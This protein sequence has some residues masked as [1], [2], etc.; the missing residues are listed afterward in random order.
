MKI[1]KLAI[2]NIASIE[3]AELDFEHGA[4]GE[5]PLFLICGETGA[6][7]T[8][9]LDC[10]TLALYGKT[11]RYDGVQ[12]RNA[13]EIGGYAYNDARQLV[14]HGAA[15]ARAALSLTGNDGKPYEAEWS[16]EAVSKGPNKGAFKGATWI[17]KDCSPGG[18]SRTKVKEC[19]AAALRATGLG[20][21]QFCRT[22]MLAQGQFTKFLLGTE[23]EKAEILEKLTDTSRYS[24]LGKAIALKYAE[25]SEGVKA[26]DAEIARIPG[27]GD[28]RGEVENRIR[29]LT[30]Q[31]EELAQKSLSANA[32]LLW[33]TRRRE[34][35]SNRDSV[36]GKLVEAFAALNAL[37]SKFDRDIAAV[38]AKLGE[39]RTFL[40]ENAGKATMFESAGVIL[41]NLADIRKA[42]RDGKK[43]ETALIRFE[44]EL[45]GLNGRVEAA[46]ATLENTRRAFADAETV[47]AAEEEKLAALDRD[48]VQKA[49]SETEKLRGNL[50]GLQGRINGISKLEGLLAEKERELVRQ[51]AKRTE[52]EHRLPGL[53]SEME[54][55]QRTVVQVRANR[56]AKKKLVEDGIE[57]LVSDLKIGDTCPIC[58]N[59]IETLRAKGHF[60]ALFRALEA[61]CVKAEERCTRIERSYGET[62]AAFDALR[63]AIASSETAMLRAKEKIARETS[64][65]S[66]SARLYGIADGSLERVDAAVGECES[67]ISA[68]DVK[69]SGIAR[70]EKKIALLR[71]RLKGLGKKRDADVDC[72]AQAEKCV[73]RCENQIK[74][75]QAAIQTERERAE[76]K[77]SDVERRVTV[78]GWL[79]GWEEDAETVESAFKD[80]AD[81]YA[82]RKA[83]LPETEEK[84]AALEKERNQI[85]ECI[86][87]AVSAD[88]TLAAVPGGGR[89]ARSTAEMEGLLGRFAEADAALER[90]LAERPEGLLETDTAENL[91]VLCDGFRSEGRE[92]NEELG[93]CRQQI[94]DDDACTLERQKKREESGRLQTELREWFPI[95]EQF[96]D[97]EGKKIRREIQSYVLENVLVKAN[98]YLEQLSDRYELS[99]EGLTLSVRDAF[100]GGVARP[101][102]T[103]SGGEQFLVSLALALGL[104]G[105][106]ETGLGVDMLLIDEGF[107][108]LSG[109][110]L[111]SAIE[112]L[113]RLNVLTGSRKVG[114]ISHV[115]RL[116][117]RIRTH[118]EV[119][120]NGHDP[121]RVQV[122]SV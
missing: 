59:R 54:C 8:T 26:L 99:C 56:D 42:R 113:E 110:H 35:A 25:L 105:T 23:D 71:E 4:L 52:L 103:L 102:N 29:E 21:E 32:K 107:G 120:R 75:C 12:K 48:G 17:W 41:Q 6:G 30:E 14:R 76:K 74:I 39:L 43:A 57:K 58:G 20:F 9:V 5:A 1:R 7:K 84:L 82:A 73:S 95:A 44:H 31:I 3:S 85:A 18:I 66:E 114:V 112:A 121:S 2:E 119:T 117:E 77:R 90:H 100:E 69:L 28:R 79:D 93:R 11:P 19:E 67:R 60:E 63:A 37:G 68:F 50:Q 78:P 83:T 86:R 40:S 116:R 108:T 111:N 89:T 118:I 88:G 122:V 70:Q 34:L 36:R 15:S 51:R 46:G 13:R 22:T 61:E 91:S 45:P 81:E 92:R 55:A 109:E 65:V 94:A 97:K 106:S 96:G 47:I 72:L 98:G 16:V 80:A 62:F 104:A 24:N 64:A 27:L 87:R 10:I 115:E 49:K 53:K 38:K 33:L 101:V